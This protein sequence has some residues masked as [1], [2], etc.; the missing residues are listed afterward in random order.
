MAG[1]YLS[2]IAGLSIDRTSDVRAVEISR[3]TGRATWFSFGT[4][5]WKE[6]Q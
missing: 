6:R 4:G 1:V 5:T 3:A 2:T